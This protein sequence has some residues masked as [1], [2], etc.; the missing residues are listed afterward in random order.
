[1]TQF[2]EYPA[3]SIAQKSPQIYLRE[4]PQDVIRG[5]TPQCVSYYAKRAEEM[6][7]FI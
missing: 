1:M 4:R 5:T 6:S 3:S 2:Y 7:P